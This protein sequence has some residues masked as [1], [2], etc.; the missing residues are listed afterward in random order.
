MEEIFGWMKTVGLLDKLRLRGVELA[1]WIF[2]FTAAAYNLVR[3]RNLMA[4]T[5]AAA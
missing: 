1:N 3:V 2:L 5:P 4:A